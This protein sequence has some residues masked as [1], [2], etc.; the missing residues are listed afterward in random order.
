M[1]NNE[2]KVVRSKENKVIAGRV[3]S[4]F[5]NRASLFGTPEYEA[6][7]NFSMKYPKARM[8]VIKTS[9]PKRKS[10][11]EKKIR[12]TYEQMTRFIKTQPN[13]EYNLNK[14]KQTK[15][16]AAI[17]GKSY[18]ATVNWFNNTFENTDDYKLAFRGINPEEKTETAEN[19]KDNNVIEMKAVNA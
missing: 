13:A 2:I 7:E 15:N 5:R 6:W 16:M 17:S 8:M 12:P 14:M 1:K 9:K 18:S 3:T 19:P 11:A 4:A 10:V